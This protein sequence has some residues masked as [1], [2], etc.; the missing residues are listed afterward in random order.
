MHVEL[1]PN[2]GLADVQTALLAI[3]GE[4]RGQHMDLGCRIKA[5]G[6]VL[7]YGG[8]I[9]PHDP[10]VI[11]DCPDDESKAALFERAAKP[12]ADADAVPWS[13]ILSVVVSLLE[14]WLKK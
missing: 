14:K 2:I 4:F 8:Q 13:L 6:V 3:A 1:T 9:A 7:A 11:G 10:P 5:A 12:G